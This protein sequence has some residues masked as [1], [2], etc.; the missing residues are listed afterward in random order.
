MNEYEVFQAADGSFKVVKV[1]FCWLGFVFGYFWLMS[2]RLWVQAFIF[3]VI[4][5]TM[6]AF[7]IYISTLSLSG[8]SDPAIGW[9]KSLLQLFMHI[10][11]GWSGNEW[12]STK[13]RNDNY[14]F[15]RKIQAKDLEQAIAMTTVYS[16]R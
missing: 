3:F 11:V 5:M 14:R 1:G 8:L 15:K 9:L 6:L 2:R 7:L 13:F 10:I 16:M 12:L 4:A